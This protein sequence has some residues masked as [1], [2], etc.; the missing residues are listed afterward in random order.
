MEGIIEKILWVLVAS[1]FGACIVAS[2]LPGGE[3]VGEAVAGVYEPEVDLIEDA[4]AD[5]AEGFL[6]SQT[7]PQ[8]QEIH[9]TDPASAWCEQ[10]SLDYSGAEAYL[11][12][13]IAWAEARGEG[14]EGMALVIRVVLNRVWSPEFPDTISDVIFQEGQFAGVFSDAWDIVD[15]PQAAWDA[16]ALVESGWDE[17]QGATY[18]CRTGES[19]W[20]SE[21]LQE[22][23][24][25]GNH[26]FYR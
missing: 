21:R 11:L 5:A 22:L 3:A 13:K 19:S 16:L 12:A 6:A 18:F 2:P 10:M 1:V 17:S 4:A 15:V 20:H 24:V 14:T 23:F 26:T 9:C 8:T 25:W 7:E